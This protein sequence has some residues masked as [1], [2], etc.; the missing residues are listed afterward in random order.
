[1][2]GRYIIFT[3][4]E[5]KEMK[6][7][8]KQ[9]EKHFKA[10]IGFT[11][12]QEIF[13]G[14][15]VPTINNTNDTP[16]YSMS[17]WGLPM[18]N[19]KKLIIN[20]RCETINEKKTF[21]NLRPIIFPANGYFEWNNKIKYFIKPKDLTTIYFAGLHDSNNNCVIITTD[22]SNSIKSIHDRMPVILNKETAKKWLINKDTSILIPYLSMLYSMKK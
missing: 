19:S 18:Y 5:Y 13:P 21:H 11:N 1:M 22:A 12:E 10:G 20:A 15:L 16:I 9:I 7:I 4:E 6:A 17:K 3:S 2:C 14:T 8:L